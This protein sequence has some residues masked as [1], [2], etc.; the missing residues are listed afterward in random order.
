[1]GVTSQIGPQRIDSQSA[2]LIGRVMEAMVK[3]WGKSPPAV[4]VTLLARQPSPG[5]IPS[6]RV[7]VSAYPLG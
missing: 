6:R 4:A 7:G 3:R 5:A 1:V 2:Y